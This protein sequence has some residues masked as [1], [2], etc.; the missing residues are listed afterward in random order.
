MHTTVMVE[1][2]HLVAGDVIAYKG[3]QVKIDHIDHESAQVKVKF[4][5][6]ESANYI[7]TQLV[8]VVSTTRTV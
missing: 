6:G 7:V 1:A 2:L 4:S 8:R 3:L 5:S